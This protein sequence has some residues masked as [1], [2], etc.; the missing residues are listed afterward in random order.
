MGEFLLS[1]PCFMQ[2]GQFSNVNYFRSMFFVVFVSSVV[3]A[4]VLT[5]KAPL[6]LTPSVLPQAISGVRLVAGRSGAHGKST[7]AP[8]LFVS[9]ALWR[10]AS[11]HFTPALVPR[12]C[13]RRQYG[14]SVRCAVMA[15]FL[16][17]FLMRCV[18]PIL[19]IGFDFSP[20]GKS[21]A[22]IKHSPR[23]LRAR[24]LWCYGCRS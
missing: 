21:C 4:R 14:A 8:R 1:S 6:P 10:C 24:G 11:R 20:R 5:V 7:I 15:V 9:C 12:L 13:S 22:W 17:L 18:A 19:P 16:F 2:A 3:G 23:A